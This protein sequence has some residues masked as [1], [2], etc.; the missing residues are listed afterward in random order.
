LT[1]CHL[2]D[3]HFREIGPREVAIRDYVNGMRPD[4]VFITGDFVEG[5]PAIVSGS[6]RWQASKPNPIEQERFDLCL[7]W[8][9]QMKARLGLWGVLG[10][11]E[12]MRGR[13]TN[14][15]VQDL[16][17]AGVR[18]LVNQNH[19]IK[20]KDS[21]FWLVG[22]DDPHTRHDDLQKAISG[23]PIEGIKIL[24]AHSPAIINEAAKLG[25]H[26]VLVGHTHGGQIRL[27]FVRPLYLN[28]KCSFKYAS[29]LFRKDETWLYVNRGIGV[30]LA[31]LRP[32]LVPEIA[33][34]RL[35]R[36]E[37][38]GQGTADKKLNLEP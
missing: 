15:I 7:K 29:G 1:I 12:H 8:L 4:L 23:I 3:L 38:R 31:I 35:K 24:L 37:A 11:K 10:N 21:F 17:S 36:D 9:G 28:I 26:L 6:G 14:S 22:V 30:S 5:L 32:F 19:P 2:S 20:D 33:L 27:P 18:V 13:D 16:E 25:V 34:L